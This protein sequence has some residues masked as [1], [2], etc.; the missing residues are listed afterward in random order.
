[1]TRKADVKIDA[2]LAWPAKEPN[3]ARKKS[4]LPETDH[5]RIE[6]GVKRTT[7]RGKAAPTPKVMAVHG[8]LVVKQE[9]GLDTVHDKMNSN[10]N[11]LALQTKIVF[12][13]RIWQE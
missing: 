12:P 9:W 10:H 1:V 4:E 11:L 2:L 13:H 7:K 6:V 3:N 5:K 8:E